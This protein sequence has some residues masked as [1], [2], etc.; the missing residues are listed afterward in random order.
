MALIR[1]INS[2]AKAE[3]NTGFGNNATDYGG[4]FI[5]KSGNA[6]IEKKGIGFFEGI[7]W[8]HSML[9]LPVWKF[10]LV[11]LIFYILVNFLFGC[12]YY[13][14]GVEHLAG[15]IMGSE[16]D[17]FG[18]AFFFSTQTFTT[19]GYG[20]ISPTGFITSALAASEAFMGLL[21]FALATG[22]FYGR[23]SKPRAY[24]RFSYN[25]L[26][27]PFKEGTALM[28]RVAPYKN[29][30]LTEAEA[31]LTLG[32][33][34]EENGKMVNRFFSLDLEYEKANALTL[35]WT[36]VHPI[37]ESSPLYNFTES[38]FASQSGEIIIFLK[39]F[40]DMF[41]NTVVTRSSYSF[42]EIVVG[43]KFVPMYKRS[44][45]GNSTILELDKLNSFVPADI[46]QQMSTANTAQS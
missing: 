30:A 40:D 7:S 15:V 46:S 13:F 4:R 6:N 31:K 36:I 38:D 45:D 5:T 43:A 9:A 37:T 24:L 10:I 19:V 3:I 12:L 33:L 8:Y 20:R 34:V 17:K 35:N 14:I 16:L 41:S 23:F 39:A 18:E 42:K 22:L 25:A 29:T 28:I 2:K 27:A 11:I 32:M 1:K 21:S 44:A 26:I